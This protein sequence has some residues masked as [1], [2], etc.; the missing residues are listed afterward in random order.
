VSKAKEVPTEPY[1]L[2]NLA[3]II[4]ALAIKGLPVL[5]SKDVELAIEH[6]NA[7]IQLKVPGEL[8]FITGRLQGMALE[9]LLNRDFEAGVRFTGARK[10]LQHIAAADFEA[11]PASIC[12]RLMPRRQFSALRSTFRRIR[13]RAVFILASLPQRSST[14]ASPLHPSRSIG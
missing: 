9:F 14:A 1:S 13:L 6:A 2:E 4:N 3:R 11:I 8:Y 5:E 12:H 7:D 10:I